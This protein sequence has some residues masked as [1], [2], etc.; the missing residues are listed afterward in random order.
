MK[1]WHRLEAADAGGDDTLV[2]GLVVDHT[3]GCGHRRVDPQRLL[4]LRDLAR[5]AS[6]RGHPGPCL[7]RSGETVGL[8]TAVNEL[9]G[10]QQP[11]LRA[12]AMEA[13]R[14]GNEAHEVL[15]RHELLDP[16]D[17]RLVQPSEAL[18]VG[19]HAALFSSATAGSG[20]PPFARDR[21]RRSFHHFR[22]CTTA[23]GMLPWISSA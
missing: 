20:G 5:P 6:F 7:V 9:A 21:R 17:E 3:L 15:T 4:A 23:G 1:H 11:V 12:V 18:V 16:F 8:D 10:D 19:L 22:P 13:R 2:T 14:L